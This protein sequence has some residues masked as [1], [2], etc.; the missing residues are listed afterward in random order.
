MHREKFFL[1][2]RNQHR[3]S[4]PIWFL[5]PIAAALSALNPTFSE[6]RGTNFLLPIS[7]ASAKNLGTSA[8]DRRHHAWH[9]S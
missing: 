4:G 5:L 8:R 2:W 6:R 9:Q 1:D 3:G 7:T